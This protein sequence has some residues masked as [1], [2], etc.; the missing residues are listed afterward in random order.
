M[1]EVFNL[2]RFGKYFLYDLKSARDSYLISLIVMGFAL[3]IVYLFIE[4]PSLIFSGHLVEFLLE[5]KLVVAFF[6]F[7]VLT[8]SISAKVY[9]G[10]TDRLTGGN[11]VLVPASALEKFISMLL[12]ICIIAPVLLGSLIFVS[13][14]LFSLFMPEYGLPLFSNLGNI[15][16]EM[17]DFPSDSGMVGLLIL[18]FLANTFMFTLGAVVFKKAKVV[19][20]FLAY[21]VFSFVVGWL[22]MIILLIICKAGGVGDISCWVCNMDVDPENFVFWVKLISYSYL[23]I[24]SLG[25]ATALYLRIKTIKH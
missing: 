24:L 13:D 6:T 4:I 9:G 22:V 19:K 5:I 1:S 23:S 2:N 12:I 14:W 17:F 7:A 8:M 16:R 3:P 10:L 20:T 15:S 25:L 21:W 11:W 18:S